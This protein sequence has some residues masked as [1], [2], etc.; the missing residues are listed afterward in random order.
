MLLTLL[1]INLMKFIILPVQ[2]HLLNIKE[3]QFKL[4]R[5]QFMDLLIY[6]KTQKKIIQKFYK[7]VRVKFTVTLKFHLKMKIILVM[8]IQSVLEV[9]TMKVKDLLKHYSLIILENFIQI[10]KSLEFLI[11]M[12]HI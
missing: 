7:Q 10:L 11:H 8:L 6:L 3:T 2:P 1:M 4:Q 12:D 5:H 9:V